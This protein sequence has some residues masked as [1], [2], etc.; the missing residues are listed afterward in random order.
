MLRIRL[1]VPLAAQEK[2]NCCWHTA[3]YMIWLYWREHTGRSGPMNTLLAD[4]DVADTTPLSATMFATLAKTVGLQELPL[5]NQ[6]LELDLYG[7]LTNHGPVWAAG[8]WFG[9]GHVI[10]LTGI[11]KGKFFFNDPDRGVAKEATVKWFNE[12]LA[13]QIPGCLMVR[14]PGSY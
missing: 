8:H 4:Y 7:Y 6:H 1:Q 2:D 14:T 10:V 13:S 5:K 12:K 3:A 11:D 9:L